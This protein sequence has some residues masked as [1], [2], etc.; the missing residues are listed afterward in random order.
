[1]FGRETLEYQKDLLT[2]K[3]REFDATMQYNRDILRQKKVQQD[4]KLAEKGYRQTEQ[5]LEQIQGGP[6]EVQ[7]AQNEQ[8]LALIE[9]QNK[10]AS[11]KETDGALHNYSTTGDISF[12]QKALANNPTLNQAWSKAGVEQVLPIDFENDKDMLAKQGITPEMYKTPEQKEA[13]RKNMWKTY[14][15]GKWGIGLFEKTAAMTGTFA[16]S[17]DTVKN[18]M[19]KNMMQFR[20]ALAGTAPA[21]PTIAARK[22][23][24][25]AEKAAT[26]A[27][28][29]DIEEKKLEAGGTAKQKDIT[30]SREYTENMLRNFGGE[31]GFYN[32]DFSKPSNFN[33]AYKDVIAIEKLE[34]TKFSEA[35]KK[36]ITEIRQLITLA[37]PA[38]ALTEK[39]TGVFD[40]MFSSAKKYM[41]EE[42]GGTRAEAAYSTF[43][44]TLRNAM[45]GSAL[46]EAEI[47]AFKESFGTLGQKLTPTLAKFKVQLEQLKAKLD[48]VKN[49]NNP[50]T[51]HVRL[52]VDQDKLEGIITALDQR[53]DLLSGKQVEQP[54]QKRSLEDLFAS[55]GG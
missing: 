39:Q 34:G 8:I 15:Q 30:R 25:E 10:S 22:L 49:V 4:L 48:S 51:S 52:G 27:R 18:D 55:T 16:R 1:M 14:G 31:E 45:F 9:Q 19:T 44:N 54:T 43:R 2:E 28:M 6:A 41:S 7:K 17:S 37:D 23:D 3:K 40:S 53:L 20:A 5:G 50:Y 33:K 11:L 32:T 13:V 38:I 36:Q 46:T 21:D 24:I 26:H 35:D 29:A 47:K 12:L 42:V